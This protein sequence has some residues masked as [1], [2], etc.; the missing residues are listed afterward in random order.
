MYNCSVQHIYFKTWHVMLACK[1]HVLQIYVLDE[2]KTAKN[3]KYFE[4]VLNS[5]YCLVLA[6]CDL[7]FDLLLDTVD[8]S[9]N[10]GSVYN[11]CDSVSYKSP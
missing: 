8:L 6:A 9:I 4:P 1:G 5:F 10:V 2:S 3:T 7:E 11:V